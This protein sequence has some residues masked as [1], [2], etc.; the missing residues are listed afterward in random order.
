[1]EDT[2]LKD[3]PYTYIHTHTHIQYI[4]YILYIKLTFSVCIYSDCSV[5]NESDGIVLF[6][7]KARAQAIQED[8]VSLSVNHI[9]S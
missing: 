1:M 6:G 4:Q 8:I 3:R 7:H 2:G 5:I 9:T